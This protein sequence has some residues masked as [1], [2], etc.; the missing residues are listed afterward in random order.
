MIALS[1]ARDRRRAIEMVVAAFR[2]DPVERWMFP[3]FVAS[4]TTGE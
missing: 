2:E 1:A 3:R 4:A